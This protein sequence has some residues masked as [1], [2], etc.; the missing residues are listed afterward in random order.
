MFP[1]MFSPMCLFSGLLFVAAG[2]LGA[3]QRW[4]YAARVRRKAGLIHPAMPEGW[5]HWFYEGFAGLTAATHGVVTLMWLAIWIVLG[6]ALI[7]LGWRF[8]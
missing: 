3:Q 1:G 5:G 8:A 4:H 7:G 6:V 2:I